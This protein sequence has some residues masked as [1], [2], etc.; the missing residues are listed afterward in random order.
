MYT[1]LITTSEPAL[2]SFEVRQISA[3]DLVLTQFGWWGRVARVK[4]TQAGRGY[5]VYMMEYRS[6]GDWTTGRERRWVWDSEI[7]DTI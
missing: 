7:V 2:S 4:D 1:N 5:S 6:N 3:G